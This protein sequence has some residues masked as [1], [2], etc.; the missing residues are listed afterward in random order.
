LNP[1]YILNENTTIYGKKVYRQTLWYDLI[2]RKMSLKAEYQ[3]EKN[4]DNRYQN[5]DWRYVDF[6][7]ISGRYNVLKIHSIEA[8]Y[9]YEIEEESLYKS[10][11]KSDEYYGEIRTRFNR[12]L[13]L[14]HNFLLTLENGNN[15]VNKDN[16]NIKSYEFKEI[17]TIFIKR[18]YRIFTK[19]TFRRNNRTGSEY[20]NFLEN[21]YDSG[22]RVRFWRKEI[23]I[24]HLFV[25]TINQTK[26][27]FKNW[28]HFKIYETK[29]SEVRCSECKFYT[30]FRIQPLIIQDYIDKINH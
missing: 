25:F 29:F 22:E 15:E 9:S 26:D 20:L 12:N 5:S 30:L 1:N 6:Y 7:K 23:K 18:K 13:I 28:C 14:N 2:H 16:Y 19:V 3:M 21:E 24:L 17:A 8:G 27:Y 11:I 10:S 4:L